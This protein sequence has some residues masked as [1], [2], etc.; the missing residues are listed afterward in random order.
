MHRLLD[1]EFLTARAPSERSPRYPAS[2]RPRLES[3]WTCCWQAPPLPS[4]GFSILSACG[5]ASLRRSTVSTRS[6][7]LR[8]LIAI[9]TS[10]HFLSEEALEYPGWG[11]G[12]A[13]IRRSAPRLEAEE[14][15]ERLAAALAPGVPIR[16]SWRN[17]GGGRFCG[18]SCATYSASAP[19]RRSRRSCRRSR[20]RW[21]RPRIERIHADLVARFGRTETT[22][23]V[24][25]LG[26]LGGRE[27]DPARISI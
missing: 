16:S 15:R 13:A 26:K 1:L 10:S 3:E 12:T 7:G 23:C 11:R 8:Y 22:F 27:L 21:W 5:S 25:A 24:L 4:R 2:F 14:Y 17:S 9:F 20:T 18:S 19:C 6:A